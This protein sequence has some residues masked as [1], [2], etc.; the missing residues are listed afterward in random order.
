MKPTLTKLIVA[1][2]IAIILLLSIVFRGRGITPDDVLERIEQTKAFRYETKITMM[3]ILSAFAGESSKMDLTTVIVQ[4]NGLH[5]MAYAEGRLSYKTLVLTDEELVITVMPEKKK[6]MRV[7]L[8]HDIFQ[9]IQTECGDPRALVKQFA[10]NKCIKLGRSMVSGI[11]V[12]GFELKHLNFADGVFNKATG[13]LWVDVNTKLPT[14]IEFEFHGE[15]DQV[16]KHLLVHDLEWNIDLKTSLFEVDIANE[17]TLVLDELE[18]LPEEKALVEMLSL[19]SELTGGAYPSAMNITTLQS[20][21]MEAITIN[22]GNSKTEALLQKLKNLQTDI[23]GHTELMVSKDL[24]MTYHG[25]TVAAEFPHAVLMSWKGDNGMYKVIF[26]DLSAKQAVP[27]KLEELE[28]QPLNLKITA[29]KPYPADKSDAGSATTGLTLTWMSG[30]YATAHQVFFGI[31][32]EELSLLAEVTTESVE[33]PTLQ[34]GITYYWRVDEVHPDGPAAIGRVWSFNSG[35]FVAHWKLDDGSGNTTANSISSDLHGRLVGDPSW[36]Q[37]ITGGALQFDGLGDYVDILDS[38]DFAI[39]NRIT[40]CAWI[41]TDNILRQHAGIVTKGDRS[42][43]LQGQR[44]SFAL[45]FSCTG[46]TVPGSPWGTVYGKIDIDDDQWHHVA[47]VYDGERI[48]VYIDGQIDSSNEASGRIQLDDKQ[49]RIGGNSQN[50]SRTWSG[51]IDDVRIYTYGM[52]EK[53]VAALYSRK[54]SP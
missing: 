42:W 44:N 51:L 6:H 52:T 50:P 5:I 41:R 24:D 27:D 26:G 37:G 7:R 39:T 45:Q 14:Q 36:T 20:E 22:L 33:A 49:V 29:I 3:G 34:R 32:P 2:T 12:E 35:Q 43:R 4:D 38:N 13:R 8:T 21:F 46:L 53:E 19:F 18:L 16:L 28:A 47:G 40:V 25:D 10:D 17:S 23:E 11:N 31:N 30:A 15:N 54:E 1:I 48:S 9:K